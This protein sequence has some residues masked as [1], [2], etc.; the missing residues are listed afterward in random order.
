MKWMI[1]IIFTCVTFTASSQT[2]FTYGREKADVKDFL[3]A[4]NKNNQQPTADKKE[5]VREYLDL[6]INSRLKIREAYERGYDTLPHIKSEIEN[7]RNQVIENYMSDPEALRRLTDEAF[8]RSLKDIHA[9]HIFIS[10]KNAAGAVDTAAARIKLTEVERRLAKKEDFKS[11]A[12]QFSDD[13]SAKE[14]KGDLNYITVFTLPYD[15]ENII[16]TTPTGKYSRPF[17]SKAGYHIFKNLGERKALGKIKVQQILLA[18]PP[19]ID[20]A[21]KTRTARLADSIYQRIRAGEDFG[22]L[23]TAFS[24]DYISVATGG[25]IPDVSVGQYDP[26]FEKVAWSLKDG[27]LSKPFATSH[28]YHIIKRISAKPITTNAADQANISELQQKVRT[29][30]RWKTANDF[31]YT[32]VKNKAGFNKAGYRDDVL[33]ALTDSILDQKP[34]G[35][36]RNMNTRSPLFTIGDT[37]IRVTDWINYGQAHRYKPDRSSLKAYPDLMDEFSKHILYQYYRSHMEQFNEDFRYQMEEFRDGNLFFE[38]MQQEVWNKAQSDSAALYALYEKNKGQYQW[39]QSADAIIFFC[40]EE[41]IAKNLFEQLKKDPVSWKT[42]I[43]SLN[44]KVVA[45]SG[46]YEWQVIPGVGPHDPK[47]GTLT[48]VTTNP[49]D[50]SASFAYINK[51]YSQPETRSFDEAKGLVMNDYQVSLE[52]EWIRQLKKKYPVD[53]DQKVLASI[54]K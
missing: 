46:R 11:V 16:Y 32:A 24:N 3:R 34:A 42:A 40:S 27:A 35:N 22:K 17:A 39:K 28:G 15:F 43:E 19:G 1:P 51:V 14:N 12:Q 45:D 50:Q 49:T 53:V 30:D 7:L 36:G 20:E 47:A 5:A 4:F 26:A 41:G 9:A 25:N 37:T 21:G 29:D 18:F 48:P 44:E 33:W 38:I 54:S 23:A 6:Y 8:Q 31:I 10:F 2:L 52:Q 13:P